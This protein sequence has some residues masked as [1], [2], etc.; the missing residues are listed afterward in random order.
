MAYRSEKGFLPEDEIWA[1]VA[2]LQLRFPNG[3]FTKVKIMQKLG[4]E[5]LNEV[6][7][8]ELLNALLDEGCIA[9][10]PPSSGKSRMLCQ[11]S[12]GRFRLFRPGDLTHPGRV[13]R[14]KMSKSLP[15]WE[16]IPPQFRFLL[17]WYELW[18]QE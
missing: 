14:G 5:G 4:S 12:P 11:V 2:L 9:D 6:T 1:A 17:G 13:W 7:D 15:N 16:A 18:V 10:M 8:R 3:A